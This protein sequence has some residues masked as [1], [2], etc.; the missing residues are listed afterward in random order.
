MRVSARAARPL[1]RVASA[2]RPPT[3]TPARASRPG[4]QLDGRPPGP[5]DRATG[6]R[7]ALAQARPSS[8]A[9]GR[10][11]CGQSDRDRDRR[12][13]RGPWRG[14]LI[15]S[16]AAAPSSGASRASS[17]TT[18]PSSPSSPGQL[19][20]RSDDLA[21]RVL[22]PPSIEPSHAAGHELRLAVGPPPPP[23]HPTTRELHRTSSA[24][25]WTRA[26]PL[27]LARTR[28]EPAA[29]ASGN[30]WCCA[31]SRA[32]ASTR[33]LDDHHP[34]RRRHD[35]SRRSTASNNFLGQIG[36]SE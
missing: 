32:L 15:P 17:P 20:P 25:S 18:R 34:S 22:S 16:L 30:C 11:S 35:G 10:R 13:R 1:P 31:R 8:T 5:R 12:R 21:H 19:L 28:A 7:P 14:C 26:P 6:K 27:A 2:A 33:V 36:N 29:G 23:Q 24:R 3:P 4:S 9:T